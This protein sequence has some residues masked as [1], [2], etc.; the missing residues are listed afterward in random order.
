MELE[1][2][3]PSKELFGIGP[4]SLWQAIYTLE[5]SSR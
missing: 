4:E 5:A 2:G 3:N 1:V